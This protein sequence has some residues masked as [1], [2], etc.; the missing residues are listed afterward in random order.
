MQGP[1]PGY[2]GSGRR[3]GG[4]IHLEGKLR[5]GELGERMTRLESSDERLVR[6]TSTLA[7]GQLLDLKTFS[8]GQDDRDETGRWQPAPNANLH[9]LTVAARPGNQPAESGV[10]CAADE[11][12][13]PG[14]R[15]S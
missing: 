13:P 11:L 3:P 12:P 5:S 1:I 14:C 7:V 15:L 4:E 10:G 8:E 2:R 9:P 6:P